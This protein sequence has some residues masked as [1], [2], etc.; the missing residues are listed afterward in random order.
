MKGWRCQYQ[1]SR[2]TKG[3]YISD[4]ADHSFKK[5]VKALP[6][7]GLDCEG[8]WDT[9][10][11]DGRCARQVV[12]VQNQDIKTQHGQETKGISEIC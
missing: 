5:W 6:A 4:S 7:F 2:P 8:D 1:I 12:W 9:V 10:W 3:E 11:T